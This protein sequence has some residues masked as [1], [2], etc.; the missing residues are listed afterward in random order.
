MCFYH[1][2]YAEFCTIQVVAGRK[3]H[4]CDECFRQIPA[5]ELSQYISGKY[6]G[7]LFSNYYCGECEATRFRVH[8]MEL[9]EGCKG[10]ETWCPYGDLADYCREMEIKRSTHRGGQIY[11]RK[12]KREKA[13]EKA[14]RVARKLSTSQV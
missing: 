1:D 5:G 4:Q 2:G 3:P 10:A 6:E 13:A 11:L 9:A 8:L 7:E 12:V 14:A